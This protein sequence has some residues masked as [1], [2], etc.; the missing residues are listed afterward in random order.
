MA[1]EAGAH[2]ESGEMANMKTIGGRIGAP[3]EVSRC[4]VKGGEVFDSGLGVEAAPDE[5]FG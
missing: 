5:F 3:V 4:G 2:H 1:D